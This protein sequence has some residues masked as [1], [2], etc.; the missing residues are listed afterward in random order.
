MNVTALTL[1]TKLIAAFFLMALLT[2]GLGA[3]AV[4]QLGKVNANMEAIASNALPSVEVAGNL[5][6]TANRLRRAEAD[7][8]LAT[9]DADKTALENRMLELRREL[10][11]Q[12][13][14]YE[15]LVS[16]GDERVAY[17][18]YKSHRDA[19]L[20][21]IDGM[22]PL[23]RAGEQG[24]GAAKAYFRQRSGAAFEVLANDLS[25]LID[26]N[27]KAGDESHRAAQQAHALAWTWTLAFIAVAVG[28]AFALGLAIT[29]SV[30]RQLGG[31]PAEAARLA[32]SVA[33]G[34]LRADA[35]VGTGGPDSMMAQLRSMQEGLARMVAGVRQNADG[36]AVASAQI[37]LGNMDLSSR[38]E[39]QASALQQTAASM[40]QLG[41]TVGQNADN[42]RQA[43]ELAIGASSV[44][45]RGGAV[46]GEVVQTMKG[47]TESSRRI[48]DIIGVID[49]IAF[50]TNI[51]ALNAAVEAARAGEQGRGFAVVASEVRNLAQ[52]S[53]DAAREI[54]DLIT[55][56]VERVE[57]GTA[58]VDR[59]GETMDEVVK[60]IKR[61]ADIM[62]EITAASA[63]QS[64]GVTQVGEAVAQMDRTTQ[65]NAALV[66][67]SAA[68]AESLKGQAQK[69]VDAVAAFKLA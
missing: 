46:V 29:H 66:E 9:S 36:V 35:R 57:Q 68:A 34:D 10:V 3:F 38:T 15:P 39:E 11:D 61:V 62:G 6:L 37:A 5:R 2:A 17:E 40:E 49:G 52:R 24:F 23:S 54:K 51:L 4:V 65:Q 59:A 19:Y 67:E 1:R 27:I 60:S 56:S 50:Q 42:A 14:A 48:S 28:A 45:Q 41:S 43:N 18:E 32:R 13:R 7:H 55:T 64:A 58:L 69:L 20:A 21:A 47:I 8:L 25:H 63:E 22:V 30:A 31:E 33:E 26:I 16:E 12:Q 53:A 44:A